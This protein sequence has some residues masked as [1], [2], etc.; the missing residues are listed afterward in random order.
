MPSPNQILGRATITIAGTRI[1]SKPGAKLMPASI[2]REA[3]ADDNG[4][5]GFT[6]KVVIPTCE[7]E[8]FI[9]GNV[10]A[11]Q[12]MDIID[13]T[14]LFEGDNGYTASMQLATMATPGTASTSSSGTTFQCKVFGALVNETP[15][16][17]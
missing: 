11:Q 13:D 17:G 10:T 5:A 1:S 2:E 15:A 4:Y 12:L 6:E 16:S 14:L 3:V 7:F 9:K 8:V